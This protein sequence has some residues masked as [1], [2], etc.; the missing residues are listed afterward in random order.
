[1]SSNVKFFYI[2]GFLFTHFMSNYHHFFSLIPKPRWF[3]NLM[4]NKTKVTMLEATMSNEF[5]DKDAE[6]VVEI[7]DEIDAWDRYMKEKLHKHINPQASEDESAITIPIV[8]RRCWWTIEMPM[9]HTESQLVPYHHGKFN[10]MEKHKCQCLQEI[11][12]PNTRLC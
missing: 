9:I 5:K 12:L 6:A 8:P 1:M 11:L 4:A 7:E 10:L 3:Q 2:L